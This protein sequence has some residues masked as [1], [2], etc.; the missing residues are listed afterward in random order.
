M[1]GGTITFQIL[2]EI[3]FPLTERYVEVVVTDSLKNHKHNFFLIQV[4]YLAGSGG[5]GLY[6]D[7]LHWFN[8]SR[9]T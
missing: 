3:G 2:T 8:K 5:R 9:N 1:S 6:V 7:G 4:D